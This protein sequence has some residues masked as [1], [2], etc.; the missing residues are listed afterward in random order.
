MT[1][2]AGAKELE[3]RLLAALQR[4]RLNRNI[5]PT[6][7]TPISTNT[8]TIHI[9]DK[10]DITATHIESKREQISTG[11]LDWIHTL[12]N[13]STKPLRE[14]KMWRSRTIEAATVPEATPAQE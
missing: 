2:A 7:Q 10:A 11:I 5:D 1:A 13:S 3:E 9:E 12:E 14:W 4:T 6:V 8:P